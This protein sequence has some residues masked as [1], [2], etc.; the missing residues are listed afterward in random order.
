VQ[1]ILSNKIDMAVAM[2]Q[3]D[4][5][6]I[7]SGGGKGDVGVSMSTLGITFILTN[8]PE[9]HPLN[10]IKARQ[11]LNYAVNKD[12]YT[13]TLFKGMTKPASQPT[14]S[15][16]FGFNTELKPYPYKPDYAKQLLAEAGYP[17]GFSF[18]AQVTITGGASLASV[19]QQVASDL[20][21]VGVDM[22]L[23]IIPV[24]QLIRGIQEGVWKGEAFGMN[25]S[26]QRTTDAL[27]PIMVHSCL[28]RTPWYC[29]QAISKKI[30]V[31]FE[32]SDLQKR[33]TLTQ[34][35]M[36]IYHEQAPAIWLHEIIMMKGLSARVL[37]FKQTLNVI[38]YH[39]VDLLL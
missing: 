23:R 25:Y 2:S 37:N 32:T 36:K 17:D 11:A 29:D 15:G 5:A 12:Q 7:K 24:Q 20:K 39:E 27:R 19:Y 28:Q 3:D 10:D 38:N 8:L 21:L 33:R 30:E 26:S 4:L 1:A 22:E 14:T 35:L 31:A 13:Q 18:T 9:S 16:A 34:Q 6:T